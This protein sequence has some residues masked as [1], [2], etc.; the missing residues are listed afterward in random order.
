MN[1]DMI[2]DLLPLCADGMASESSRTAVEDHLRTCDQCRALYMRLRAPVE[3][4]TTEAELD[5]MAAVKRQKKENRRFLLRLYGV[6]L[7]A[8]FLLVLIWPGRLLFR[9]RAWM[10]ESIAVDRE[11]VEIEMPRALLTREEKDLAQI[12]FALPEV[13]D[14]F[15]AETEDPYSNLPEELY[16]DLL[17]QSGVDPDSTAGGYAAILGSAV[18]LDYY[19]SEYRIILEY[20]DADASGHTDILRKTTSRIP[21]TFGTTT[22]KPPEVGDF[23]SAEINGALIGADSEAVEERHTIYEKYAEKR[24]WLYGL[25]Q[26]LGKED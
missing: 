17:A 7:I 19:D 24:Q 8:I 2:R 14:A 15:L 6:T 22:T 10:L 25:R 4:Q 23:F 1:C 9:D 5:Y 18:I 3:V 21:E 16:L 13:Q 11:T 12:I 26:L 20:L